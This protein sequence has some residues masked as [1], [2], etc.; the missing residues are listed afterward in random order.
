MK[1][2]QLTGVLDDNFDSNVSE[3]PHILHYAHELA[4]RDVDITNMRKTCNQLEQMVHKVNKELVLN[5]EKSTEEINRLKEEVS[6]F[7]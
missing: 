4:R 6:R 5:K 3:S 1:H 2:S 7:I